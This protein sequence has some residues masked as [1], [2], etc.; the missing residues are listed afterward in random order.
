MTMTKLRLNTAV[1]MPTQP[2]ISSNV[3]LKA[4]LVRD[5]VRANANVSS[6]TLA[7]RIKSLLNKTNIVEQSVMSA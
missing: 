7:Y 1:A 5:A 6:L 4:R 3:N 2:F